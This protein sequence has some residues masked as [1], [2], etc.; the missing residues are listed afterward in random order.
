MAKSL[1]GKKNA[2]IQSGKFISTAEGEEGSKLFSNLILVSFSAFDNFKMITE[3]NASSEDLPYSYIGLRRI[4]NNNETGVP[5]TFETLVREFVQSAEICMRGVRIE[6]WQRALKVLEADPMFKDLAISLLP[7]KPFSEDIAATFR[8]L[9]SGHKIVLLTITRLVETA[10]DKTLLLFD[11]PESHLHPPMI[12]AFIRA[13]SDLMTDRNSVAIIA[14]HS[15]VVLQ[16]VPKTCVW[17]LDR[18]GSNVV[19][20]RPEI[21]TFGENVGVLTREIF[22]Y[23]VTESGFHKMLYNAV[24]EGLSFDQV[25]TRFNGELGAEARAI[26]RAL[27]VTREPQ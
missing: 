13:L 12:S 6:R 21:E 20:Q 25:V 9:S 4:D 2:A 15:P 27:S 19:A 22:G 18:T 26:L 16:E 23:E 3:K 10:A 14:T 11:E 5:K 7:T 1:V 24:Q 17:A 8:G